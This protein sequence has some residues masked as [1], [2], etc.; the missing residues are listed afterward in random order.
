MSVEHISYSPRSTGGKATNGAQRHVLIFFVPG[1]PGLIEYYKPFLSALRDLIDS[2]P[3]LNN[4]EESGVSLHI[5]GQ[6]LRGFSDDDHEPFTSRRKPYS[7][8]QQVEHTIR[9]LSSQRVR[10]PGSEDNDKLF[11]AVLLIGHS[12]GSFIALEICHRVL[13][14][15]ALAPDLNGRLNS[16]I[17]LF[18]TIDHI[19]DSPSGQKLDL[20]RQTPLLGDN[21]YR[22]AQGFLRLWPYRMLH[23]FVRR[24]L[25][26]PPHAADITTRWLK[27]R[28]GV[29]QS[30]HLG[31]GNCSILSFPV[32]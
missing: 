30:L 15:P 1:N 25:G 18:P 29:W 16:G 26:F 13:Q 4:P 21:A 9:G 14:D 7:L 12:V 5:Y 24:V 17:L 19:A 27:S 8:E 6:S 31:M 20:L 10:V 32:F 3:S 11:D 23:Y 22:I 28:D 2:N